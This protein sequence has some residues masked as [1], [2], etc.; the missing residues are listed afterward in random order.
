MAFVRAG[1][2]LGDRVKAT[3]S[4][5]LGESLGSA[6][7]AQRARQRRQNV[8]VEAFFHLEFEQRTETK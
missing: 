7:K 4:F 8:A 3:V 6:G 2:K 1:D 5:R